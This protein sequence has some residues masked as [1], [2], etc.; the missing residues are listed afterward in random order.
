MCSSSQKS[1]QPRMRSLDSVS[2]PQLNWAG[3][4]KISYLRRMKMKTLSVVALSVLFFTGSI[5][6]RQ[7]EGTAQRDSSSGS[8]YKVAKKSDS[9]AKAGKK[10][11]A[12]AVDADGVPLARA[13]HV[14][15]LAKA[16]PGNGG[17]TQNGPAGAA[18]D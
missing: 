14:E 16:I 11:S 5:F 3:K 12:A 4:T 15:K 2:R 18:E 8:D 17:E 6:A 7:Q 10:Q 9:K 1:G 13:R